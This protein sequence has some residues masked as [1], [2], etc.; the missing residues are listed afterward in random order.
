MM[1]FKIKDKCNICKKI[2]FTYNS[3]DLPGLPITEIFLRSPNYK[4][5]ILFDQKINYCQSCHHMQLQ[6]QYD[7]SY[8]YNKDYLTSSTNSYSGRYTNDIFYEF[9]K[10]NIDQN[11]KYNILEIGANDLYLI[12]KMKKFIRSSCTIDPCIK[13]DSRLKKIKYIKKF[14]ENTSIN[15]IDFIPDIVVC[16]HTLEHIED[17][18]K[19]IKMLTSFGDDKT[20]YF[21]QFPSCESLLDRRAFDQIHHQHF[22]FFSINSISKLLKKIKFDVKEIDIGEL[23]Y[24]SLMIYFKKSKDNI[25]SINPNV[26]KFNG[27]LSDIYYDYKMYMKNLIQIIKKYQKRGSKVYGIGAGLM[28]PLVNYHL[29]DLLKDFDGILDDDKNKLN[30]FY[31]NLSTKISSLKKADLSNAVAVI[32]STASSV[33]TRKLVEVCRLNNAKIII[34]PSMTI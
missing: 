6:N 12:K 17:P 4:K 9:I 19:F 5:K 14:L 1:K 18:K 10:S 26:Q 16:S 33:T 23:H 2:F 31:P 30:K 11:K 29:N 7:T 34:I 24:G 25:K 15:E 13:P 21:F 28:L 3:I 22:N 20:K 27:K 8:F 32:C